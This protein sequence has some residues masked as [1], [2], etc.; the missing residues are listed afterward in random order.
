MIICKRLVHPDDQLQESGL[1]GGSFATRL[2]HSGDH[3]QEVGQSGWSLAFVIW[4]CL[5]WFV[6]C[7]MLK[8]AVL[9]Q[10]G[11]RY[12]N[13][14]TALP[15]ICTW[16]TFLAR[17]WLGY[18]PWNQVLCRHFVGTSSPFSW[19]QQRQFVW[20]GENLKVFQES[21]AVDLFG[22]LCCLLLRSTIK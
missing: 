3:L 5:S 2:V 20:C 16:K 4:R 21:Q 15:G 22:G 6:V 1:S 13:L 7:T 17:C 11:F 19:N 9:V 14:S 8:T 12:G 18:L 10:V